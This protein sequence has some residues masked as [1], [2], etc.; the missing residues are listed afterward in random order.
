M[1][2]NSKVKN[3][4]EFV[5]C[6]VFIKETN[7]D[8]DTHREF[9]DKAWHF[10]AIGNLGDSKKTDNTRANDVDDIKEFVIEIS[11]NTLPNSTFQTGVYNQDGSYVYPITN[12]QWTAGNPAY[13]SLYN[14]WDGSFEFRYDMG[15]QTK[16]GVSV[17]TDDE[18]IKA[19]RLANKQVWRDF[20]KWVITST[21]EDFVSQLG[22]W[23]IEDSAIYWYLF[24]ERY[25]MTDNRAK[26][27][28]W[29]YG[30]CS[31]GVY[32]FE[33]WDYDND[34][35]LGINN[36]GELTMTYGF[37]DTDYKVKELPSSGYAFN[38][39]Q[40][41]FFCRIRDLMGDRLRTKYTEYNRNGCWSA[42][43]LIKQ[44][45]DMQA[46]F[47][48]ELW[49]LD[50]ERKYERSYLEGSP[51]FLTSM[52][53]GR[54]KYQRRQFERDQEKYI[55]SK[56][57]DTSVT[58]DQ[59]MFRCNTP[60]EAVVSPN[61]TLHITPYSD[62]YLSVMFG[63]STPYQVRAKAGVEY[64]VPCP[65]STM[66]DTA[67]LI[68]NASHIQAIGDLSA[69]YIHDNDFSK[70][71]K[72]Q[73]LVIGNTTTGYENVFLENL[74]MGKNYLLE[75]LDIRN[76]PSL[77]STINLSECGN[78]REFYAEG[79]NINGVIFANG[80]RLVTA[81]L[82][83]IASLTMKNL[84]YLEDLQI[85]SYNK[86][87]TLIIENCE[88]VIDTLEMFTNASNLSRIRLIGIDWNTIRDT[89]LRAYGLRGIDAGGYESNKSVLAGD[90]FIPIAYQQELSDYHEQWP[91][92]TISYDSM[93]TQY[94]VTFVNHDGTVLDIQ[95]VNTGEAPV[96]PIT[97]E[98]NPIATP[99]RPST[100]STNYTFSKWDAENEYGVLPIVYSNR[101]ITAQYTESTRVYTV[102]YVSN[103]VTL[104]QSTAEY[105]STIFY[106]GEIPTKTDAEAAQIYNLFRSWDKSGYVDGDKTINALFDSVQYV[107]G[108]FDNKDLSELTPVEL[109]MLTKM[110]NLVTQP[111]NITNYVDIQDSL[112]FSMG[113]DVTYPDIEE[114][115]FIDSKTVFG[116]SN[117]ID[118]PTAIF[119]EDRDFTFAIDYNILSTSRAYATIAQ[120]FQTNGNNGFKIS[121]N[122][123][124]SVTVQWGSSEVTIG[125][126]NNRDIVVLRHQKGSTTLHVYAGNIPY[127]SINYQTTEAVRVPVF[128][129]TLV[130]GCS[131]SDTGNYANYV[132]GEIGWAKLWYA[133]LGDAQCRKL[134][135]WIHEDIVM[136]AYG[137]KKYDAIDQNGNAIESTSISLLADNLLENSF[138][139][140]S[141]S[142]TAGG[143]GA[144]SL[145]TLLNG[146]FYNAIPDQWKALIKRINVSYLAGNRS[147]EILQTGAYI[148]I[149]SYV[150]LMSG[151]GAPYSMEGSLYGI[152]ESPTISYMTSSDSRRRTKNGAS[153]PIP[154]WTRTPDINYQN[155]WYYVDQ[156]GSINSYRYGNSEMSG[157][158][159]E[160]SI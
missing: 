156:Y 58:A 55:G 68:Y 132:N 134:V 136:R 49:R 135:S 46:Q 21:D 144:T 18:T 138:F 125:S 1:D 147:S 80:A 90:V 50:Y 149:P 79:S 30:K 47:P 64:D 39:A 93:I 108:Y 86:L 133:D 67:V 107:D 26:N 22:S 40:S 99:T 154:Y 38:G 139:I 32:R 7:D 115:V 117:R 17:S 69:C 33:L 128:S 13:D 10:Y 150:E 74:N 126:S 66:D 141:V 159:I 8:I 37:E 53:N 23:F 105:G 127:S 89:L 36:T 6:V 75:Y 140:S 131:K 100:V 122:G 76:T 61:Y 45:D 158:L 41:V 72:L 78:L 109:M 129:N 130:F 59:I 118:T 3:A 16:D 98:T 153:D 92:L 63:N 113:Q 103:G 43:N 71:T 160:F 81:H 54:K 84:V 119:S 120:C 104:Q 14:D 29:H 4:M 101:T 73:R 97:R 114:E 24:T 12:A 5:N 121:L 96:D 151:I 9:S 155:Y 15:G 44:W 87:S 148:S 19:Q 56:Y 20:Y 51:R 157:V 11:D 95:Y 2:N 146:R 145:F 57:L 70:A 62:M 82:P 111:L 65:Y 28:F 116:G 94:V 91:D 152:P 85:A 123:S 27:T 124:G 77:V 110:Q 48:E 142:S 83:E 34:T 112:Q 25:T 52:M 137:F 102:K 42:E 88:S 60:S 31:D 35:S 106:E 143:F